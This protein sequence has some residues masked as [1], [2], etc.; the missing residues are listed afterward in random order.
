MAASAASRPTPGPAIAPEPAPE[1]SAPAARAQQRYVLPVGAAFESL[2]RFW[3]YQTPAR[4]YLV[5]G[6]RCPPLRPARLL[7]PA[8]HWT[9]VRSPGTNLNPRGRLGR[10][11]KVLKIDR[12]DP[13]KQP[14][15][16]DDG[17]EYN[18]A[19]F[20]Q[21]LQMVREGNRAGPH[22]EGFSLRAEVRTAAAPIAIPAEMPLSSLH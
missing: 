22:S 16:E 5:G 18:A 21:W 2:Q 13:S 3:L 19:A 20:A 17:M 12:S 9:C 14:R 1:H 6:D 7:L 10:R 15:A 11:F 8:S 4:F